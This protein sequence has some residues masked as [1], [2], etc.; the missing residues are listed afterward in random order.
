MVRFDYPSQ[1]PYFRHAPP[2][3]PHKK[4]EKTRLATGSSP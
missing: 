2:P 4:K 3:P 1:G